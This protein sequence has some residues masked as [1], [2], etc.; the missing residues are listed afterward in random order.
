MR[1]RALMRYQQLFLTV[2]PQCEAGYPRV[3]HPS[4]TQ[5]NISSSEESKI[6]ASFDLHV[7]GTPPAFILSQDQTLMLKFSPGQKSLLAISFPF[8][9]INR[10]CSLNNSLQNF[11]GFLALFSYQGSL[12]TLTSQL[13]YVSIIRIECQALFSLFIQLFFTSSSLT[14][15]EGFEPSRRC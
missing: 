13:E 12:L 6:S 9:V 2:I 7:L 8:T 11:Q 3:T 10:F 1:N 15:K 4:A 5:S 14:E